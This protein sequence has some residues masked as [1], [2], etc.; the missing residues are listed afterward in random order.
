[1]TT[2]VRNAI[3]QRRTRLLLCL[4]MAASIGWGHDPFAVFSVA[5]AR[6][7]EALPAP[8]VV[9][10]GDRKLPDFAFREVEANGDTR[11]WGFIEFRGRPLVVVSWATWCG[12]CR[13]ELPKLDALQSR[14]ADEG[15]LVAALSIDDLEP[16]EVAREMRARGLDRLRVFHDTQKM[17]FSSM[18]GVGVPTAIIADADGRIVARALGSVRWDDPRVLAFLRSLVRGATTRAEAERKDH[19][20]G[21]S[22]R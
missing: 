3:G 8:L 13:G 5:S 20:Q 17:F 4:L 6:A 1:M 14:L 15:I 19:P 12:V 21:G 2:A 22:P 16:I 18:G 11:D 7:D 10:S 9:E